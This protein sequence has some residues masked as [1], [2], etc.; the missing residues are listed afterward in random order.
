MTEKSNF[1]SSIEQLAGAISLVPSV[2]DQSEPTADSPYELLL[3]AL[4]AH[5]A[6]ETTGL[7]E[8]RRIAETSSDPVVRL[9]MD[10]VLEDEERHHLLMGRLAARLRD[11]LLWTH[12]SE[13]LP[14]QEQAVSPSSDEWA[15]IRSLVLQEEDGIRHLQGFEVQVEGLHD[16]LPSLILQTMI[17][18]SEKHERILRFIYRRLGARLDPSQVA[19]DAD[20]T[21]GVAER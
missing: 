13:A 5:I 14:S 1:T 8:Y 2:S 16:G 6:N 20:Q 11:D 9:L 7:V 3:S 12:S 10:L 19:H 15:A 17:M 21:P 18:D 4:Q